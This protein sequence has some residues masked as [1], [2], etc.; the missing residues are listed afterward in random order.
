MAGLIAKG[1][2][3]RARPYRP[4]HHSASMAALTGGGV[5]A[6]PGETN[7][8]KPINKGF[9][10]AGSLTLVGTLLLALIYVGN[11][12]ASAGWK[13]FGAVAIGLVLAQAV[14]RLT[15]Y[16]TATHHAPVKEIAA[17]AETGPATLVLSGTSAGLESL[18]Y[19]AIAWSIS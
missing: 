1:E 8:L 2:L 16:Y 12:E 9:L 3:S 18:V 14:S 15:E 10:V 17:S 6:K 5:K 13:C 11:D 19:A 4:P 7:A